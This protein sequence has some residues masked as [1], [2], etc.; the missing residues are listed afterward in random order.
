MTMYF[1]HNGVDKP[2]INILMID[3]SSD[4]KL[5]LWREL[6]MVNMCTEVGGPTGGKQ[7][8]L[9]AWESA[10]TSG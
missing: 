6:Q 10:R 8:A 5:I 2:I 4:E 7:G 3:P 9:A 1:Q